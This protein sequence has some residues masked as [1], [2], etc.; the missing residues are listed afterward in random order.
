VEV[1]DLSKSWR[2]SIEE[3][4]ER[5]ERLAAILMALMCGVE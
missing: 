1:G 3:E 2:R 4:A 5:V